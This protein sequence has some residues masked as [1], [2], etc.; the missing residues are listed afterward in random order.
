MYGSLT[1]W[2]LRSKK[3]YLGDGPKFMGIVNVT[4]DSFSDGGQY[5]DTDRAVEHALQLARDGADILDIGGESTRP[6]SNEVSLDEE[7]AR[8]IPV[9]ERVVNLTDVPVS[10]DTS[11]A[12]VAAA[13]IEMGA[14]IINDVSGFR[15]QGMIDVA[16]KT[17]SA[18]CAMHMQGTPKTMQDN[19]HYEN[20]TEDIFTFLKQRKQQLV[21]AGID[22]ARICLDPGVGFG[23][24]HQHN[25]TLIHQCSRFNEL[26]VPILIGHSRKRFI[27]KMLGDDACDRDAATAAL[28]IYMS[29]CG[30][31]VIRVHNIRL[32]RQMIEVYRAAC[33][34]V[35]PSIGS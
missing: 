22:I 7:L 10:V 4:P 6:Y 3:L 17:H 14:E 21:S 12:E 35:H 34:G 31:N 23:K 24:S 1:H 20:V 19:P 8:V 2:Q 9:I 18:I 29:M 30:I 28:A 25:L 27:A 16:L 26:D 11:K 33:T 13:A 5:Y 32:C 15:D